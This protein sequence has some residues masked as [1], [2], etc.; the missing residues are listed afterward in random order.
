MSSSDLQVSVAPLPRREVEYFDSISLPVIIKNS[1]SNPLVV[2][3]ITVRFQT[4]SGTADYYHKTELAHELAPF[5]PFAS[6]IV[7]TPTLE[8][9]KGTNEFSLMVRYRKILANVLGDQLHEQYP[10]AYVIVKSCS[11][12]LGQ[13]FVSFKQ[14]EDRRLAR[15]V[16]RLGE[17]AGFQPYLAMNDPVPGQDL[18]E[19]IEPRLLESVAVAFIWTEFT[20]WGAGVDRE[21]SLCQANNIQHVLLI[22]RGVELPNKFKGTGIEYQSFDSEDAFGECAKAVTALRRILLTKASNI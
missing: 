4:D 12:K 11:K 17:R 15:I 16:E 5:S 10:G 19:R 21:I 1:C 3:S 14:P 8:F 9:L 18:W 7:L 13:L 2:D 6:E 22:Q 20:E